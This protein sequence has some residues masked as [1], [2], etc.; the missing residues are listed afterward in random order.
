MGERRPRAESRDHVSTD[1][2]AELAGVPE[3]TVRSWAS[4]GLLLAVATVN[5][6]RYYAAAEVLRVEARTRRRPR[7]RRLVGMATD[8]LQH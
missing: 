2:A 6:V 8:D 1:Q 5:G 3:G 7:L 4:R